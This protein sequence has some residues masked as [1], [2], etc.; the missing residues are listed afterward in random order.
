MGG[1]EKS[2][3]YLERL[4]KEIAELHRNYI[5]H[6]SS[7]SLYA[8]FQTPFILILLLAALYIV[9]K[10]F[11][12][13]GLE[14]FVSLLNFVIF[15]TFASLIAWGYSRLT[16]KYQG[17]GSAI[18]DVAVFIQEVRIQSIIHKPSLAALHF[19]ILVFISTKL[20]LFQVYMLPK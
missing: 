3:V 12:L 17:V 16:G 2:K 5:S 14:P 4:E 10:L 9:L 7:K 19:A 13:V 11:E 8:S 20:S 6:N 18:D 15:I 1:K